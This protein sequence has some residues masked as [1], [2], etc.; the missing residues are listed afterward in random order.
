[1]DDKS[2]LVTNSA[3]MRLIA[4]QTLLNRGDFDRLRA[5][6]DDNY[7]AS[8]LE[9]ESAEDRLTALQA[10]MAQAGKLRVYQLL[11]SDKYQ[12]VVL[13][14]PQQDDG[15]YIADITVEEEFP[16]RVSSY[17]IQRMES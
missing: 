3:G 10:L 2:A 13:M 12:V 5:Y 4:Q 7:T 17:S 8:A 9:A 11:A 14:E 1:M 15:F 16:H 6:I